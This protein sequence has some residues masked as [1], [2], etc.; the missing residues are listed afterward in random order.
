MPKQRYMRVL[1]RDKT[2]RQ[3]KAICRKTK[4]R[5]PMIEILSAIVEDAWE[6]AKKE[7][8]NAR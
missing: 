3:L 4:P 7:Q 2:H 5:V 8:W 1:V 6:L